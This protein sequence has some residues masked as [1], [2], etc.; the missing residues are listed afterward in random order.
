MRPTTGGSAADAPAPR[1]R[2]EDL[3][4][5]GIWLDRDAATP[6]GAQLAEGLRAA[7]AAGRFSPGDR[8]P[9]TRRIARELGVSRGV[10][11]D[12]LEL[13]VADGFAEARGGAGTFVAAAVPSS[14]TG[15]TAS[16]DGVHWRVAVPDVP[17]DV[18]DPELA[19]DL[20]SNRPS[21]DAFPME[22]WRAAWRRV[23][24]RPP[25]DDY[26]DS[27][28]DPALRHE[29]ARHAARARGV[30]GTRDDVVITNGALQAFELVARAVVPPGGAVAVE[31]PGF[32]LARVAFE[33]AGARVVPIPVDEDGLRVEGLAALDPPPALVFVTPAHQFPLGAR[34]SLARRGALL[35]W[36]HRAGAVVIEDDY[37]AEFR[38]D[39][40][41]LPSLA[42]LDDG[43]HVAYVGSFSKTLSPALRL[44]YLIGAPP[45]IERARA[46]KTTLDY[47]AGLPVQQALATLLERGD[48]ARH[49]ARMRGV[50]AERRAALVA[51]FGPLPSGVRLRGLAAGM[52]AV[53]EVPDGAIA[54]QAAAAARAEGVG[55]TTLE[56]YYLGPATVAGLVVGYGHQPADVLETSGG[57]LA[58]A[59]RGAIGVVGFGGDP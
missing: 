59:V 55:V 47:H 51:G 8:L 32:R 58:G 20:T 17:V 34:L 28:G 50:Y 4:V 33:R 22:A 45:L 29:V 36:A 9:S 31:D 3:A 48:F 49:V 13:L 39:A 18:A 23:L 44:G 56:R 21:T 43:G 19:F 41:P 57:V 46:F 27:A 54:V 37:D 12:A 5:E 16:A 25:H 40:P 10:A 11:T 30:P 15:S 52:H 35:A 26:A 6:L 24:R 38:F 2:G 53:V 42:S 1:P 14:A 7:I